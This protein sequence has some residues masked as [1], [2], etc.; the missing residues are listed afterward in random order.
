MYTHIYTYTYIYIYIH[1]ALAGR[2]AAEGGVAEDAP[3]LL[4]G[5]VDL[6][7]DGLNNKDNNDLSIFSVHIHQHMI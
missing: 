1:V 5:A 7:H 2:E 3:Q 4:R 6:P